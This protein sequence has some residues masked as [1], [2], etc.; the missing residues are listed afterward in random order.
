MGPSITHFIIATMYGRVSKGRAI[1]GAFGVLTDL[2][3]TDRQREPLHRSAHVHCGV[4]K[5]SHS[6]ILSDMI[7]VHV[8]TT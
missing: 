5:E 6:W 1:D 7:E 2:R 3:E 8:N 4:N